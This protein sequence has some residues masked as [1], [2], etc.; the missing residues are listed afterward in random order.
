MKDRVLLILLGKRGAGKTSLARLF[1]S[2][3]GFCH[4]EMSKYLLSLKDRLGQKETVL[5]YFV[6]RCIREK[7]STFLIRQ[8]RTD[9]MESIQKD[10]VITGVR[11]LSEVDYLR[12]E[13]IEYQ[14]RP[15]YLQVSLAR[16]LFRV[17]KRN[18]RR[19]IWRFIVEEF[20]SIKWGDRGLK[21]VSIRYHNRHDIEQGFAEVRE[22]LSEIKSNS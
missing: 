14:A 15:I 8:L 19:S 2:E 10:I 6:E 4:I 20:Y 17:M 21:R 12:D 13:L 1:E 22:L 11:H 3:E 16:R 9:C 18:Q 7:G 5:R